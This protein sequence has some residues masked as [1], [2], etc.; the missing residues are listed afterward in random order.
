MTTSDAE[1]LITVDGDNVGLLR[2][3]AGSRFGSDAG[4]GGVHQTMLNA[5]FGHLTTPPRGG[6]YRGS[7]WHRVD[8]AQLRVSSCPFVPRGLIRWLRMLGGRATRV[9]CLSEGSPLPRRF[10]APRAARPC[11]RGYPPSRPTLVTLGTANNQM[12]AW[13]PDNAER[14]QKHEHGRGDVLDAWWIFQTPGWHPLTSR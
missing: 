9:G 3:P 14:L 6:R 4:V 13:V 11:L 1:L 2:R 5:P 7:E 8:G 12:K 10:G